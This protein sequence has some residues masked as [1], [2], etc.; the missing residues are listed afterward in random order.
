[1]GERPASPPK[2]A[3]NPDFKKKKK[4]NRAEKMQRTTSD[5]LIP[6]ALKQKGQKG[7]CQKPYPDRDRV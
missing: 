4:R 1:M 6:H 7:S 3:E 2:I 5:G